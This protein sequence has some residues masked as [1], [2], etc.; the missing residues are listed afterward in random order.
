MFF[1]IK[2]IAKRRKEGEKMRVFIFLFTT[3][4]LHIRVNSIYM[5]WIGKLEINH[6]NSLH[7]K[8]RRRMNIHYIIIIITPLGCP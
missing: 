1:V 6:K 5:A 3:I 2:T 7:E 8:M 4:S